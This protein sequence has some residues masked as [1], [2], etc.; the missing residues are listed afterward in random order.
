MQYCLL[1]NLL[2]NT[3]QSLLNRKRNNHNRYNYFADTLQY[4]SVKIKE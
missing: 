4:A 3:N 1:C 2:T